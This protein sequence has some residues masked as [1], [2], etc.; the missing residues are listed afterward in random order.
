MIGIKNSWEMKDQ[1]VKIRYTNWKGNTSSR[2]IIPKELL[3]ESNQW[4]KEDQWF[5]L[6]WD[7][8]KKGL[9]KFAIKDIKKWS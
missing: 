5:I 1:K 3:Y 2:T 4:H 6:A 9:R 8:D 7:C